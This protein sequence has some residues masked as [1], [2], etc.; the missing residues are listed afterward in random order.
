MKYL[1]GLFMN[2]CNRIPKFRTHPQ[3]RSH[4]N[5]R[6]PPDDLR[7]FELQTPITFESRMPVAAIRFIVG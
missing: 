5:L 2:S 1:T 4:M 7:V 6:S 3:K